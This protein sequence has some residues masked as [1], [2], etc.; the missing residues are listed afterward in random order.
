MFLSRREALR[1][2]L[3][4]SGGAKRGEQLQGDSGSVSSGA[5]MGN[6][7]LLRSISSALLGKDPSTHGARSTD[8]SKHGGSSKCVPVAVRLRAAVVL[9]C[10]QEPSV[11]F[12]SKPVA[13]ALRLQRGDGLLP[14]FGNWPHRPS[15]SRPMN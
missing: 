3:S 2:A 12:R 11:F 5:R 13:P 9:C 6:G 4:V 14:L 7:V 1:S 8:G 10:V 15:S